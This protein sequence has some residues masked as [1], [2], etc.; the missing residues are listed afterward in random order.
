M[1]D[2]TPPTP[3]GFVL[4]ER[5][6]QTQALIDVFVELK[7]N[8]VAPYALLA[9]KCKIDVAAIKKRMQSART[10]A[11]SEHH[12]IIDVIRN[13]GVVRLNQENV[14]APVARQRLR[15]RSAAK[16][17]IELIRDGV[18]DFAKLTPETRS[19][20]FM[21]KAV[22][23]TAILAS[24]K[25]SRKTLEDHATTSNEELKLGRTLELLKGL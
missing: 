20:L 22:L 5:H 19:R 18:T 21:E 2:E 1:P 24:E 8:E 16:K 6:W 10:I 15:M 14:T 3:T 17:G 13:V 23:G 7:E 11:L 25:S 9:E 4:R 12:I